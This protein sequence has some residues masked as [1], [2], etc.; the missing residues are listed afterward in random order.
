MEPPK[1]CKRCTRPVVVE[2]ARYDIFEGMHYVCFHYEYEHLEQFD[3][4]EECQAGGCPSRAVNPR[5]QWAL[6][7]RV[8]G[9]PRK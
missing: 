4:D 2:A 5:P 7:D 3:V 1:I 9:A 8:E 6:Q